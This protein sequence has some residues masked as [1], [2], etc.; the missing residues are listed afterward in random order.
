MKSCSSCEI[1]KEVAVRYPG[2]NDRY[3]VYRII[4]QWCSK[5][6]I[7]AE[8]DVRYYMTENSERGI[9]TT[10]FWTIPD[11]KERM[12]FILRWCK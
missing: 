5:N 9:F 7:S 11:E 3:T 8:F 4:S 12:F 2:E 1:S 10:T 6:N